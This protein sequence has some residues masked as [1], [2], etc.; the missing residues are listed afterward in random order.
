MSSQDIVDS[1]SGLFSFGLSR[2][3]TICGINPPLMIGGSGPGSEAMSTPAT[4]WWRRQSG[5]TDLRNVVDDIEKRRVP[6]AKSGVAAI[7]ERPAPQRSL[8]LPA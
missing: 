4:R 1:S 6:V 7:A 3:I 5:T 2:N 8:E